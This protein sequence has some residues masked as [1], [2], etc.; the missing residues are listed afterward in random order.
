MAMG[1]GR[2]DVRKAG[3]QLKQVQGKTVR[4]V[5]HSFNNRVCD[6]MLDFVFLEI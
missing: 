6:D 1:S 2:G 4:C 5:L 3:E